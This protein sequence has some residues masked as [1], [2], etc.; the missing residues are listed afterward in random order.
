[1][2]KLAL[3]EIRGSRI[4]MTQSA[5]VSASGGALDVSAA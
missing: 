4:A 5:S 1:M 2:T 3:I